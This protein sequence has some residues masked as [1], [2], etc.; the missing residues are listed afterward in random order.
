[1]EEDSLAWL[2]VKKDPE[3]NEPADIELQLYFHSEDNETI[4]KSMW[5]NET[6]FGIFN[7]SNMNDTDLR[8]F[9]LLYFYRN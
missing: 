4:V 3:T 5:L 9:F 1:M 6:N 2:E 8:V 7:Q